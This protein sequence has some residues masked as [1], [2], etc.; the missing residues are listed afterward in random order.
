MDF[1]HR[2]LD[3][4]CTRLDSKCSASLAPVIEARECNTCVEAGGNC[5]GSRGLLLNRLCELS[6]KKQV[7]FGIWDHL[8]LHDSQNW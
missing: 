7:Y 5:A 1:I 4:H 8:Y 6:E 2:R 3:S